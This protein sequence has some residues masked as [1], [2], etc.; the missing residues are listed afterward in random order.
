MGGVKWN[1][2]TKRALKVIHE[3][4]REDGKNEKK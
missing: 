4:R 3:K 1:T 2:T